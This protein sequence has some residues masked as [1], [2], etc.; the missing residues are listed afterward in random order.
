VLAAAGAQVALNTYLYGEPSLRGKGP[1]FLMARIV[2]DGP[3]KWYLQRHCGQVKLAICDRVDELPNSAGDFLWADEGIWIN[4]SL[5]EQEQLRRDE[6]PLLFGTL[7][8]YPR[9]ELVIA[10]GNFWRQL[11]TFAL[12]DYDANAWTSEMMDTV[13]PGGRAEYLQSRQNRERLHEG[14]FTQVQR[15]TV[16]ASL[17]MIGV[18]FL[19]MGRRWSSRVVGLAAV[20]A[21]VVIANAAVTGML[22]NVDDRYQGRV[23]WLMPLLAGLLMMAWVDQRRSAGALETS[24]SIEQV[25][26]TTA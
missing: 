22:S 12:S 4:S 20:I 6:I 15:W 18:S 13:L 25:H 19:V 26:S 8:E 24:A 3:G 10:G 9:E 14:F 17:V 7:R 16:A 11:Q 5:E 2:G 1:A 23:I 21:F